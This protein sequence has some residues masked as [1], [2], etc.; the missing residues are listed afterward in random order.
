MPSVTVNAKDPGNPVPN[1]ATC[2]PTDQTI[3]WHL[4]PSAAA[5]AAQPILFPTRAGFGKWPGGKPI[6]N[7]K[8]NTVTVSI[9]QVLRGK[10]EKIPY[11]YTVV[12][13]NGKSFDPDIENTGP[14]GDPDDGKHKPQ[15]RRKKA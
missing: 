15:T 5:F 9:N 3:T 10:S 7:V 11:K 2:S 12:L 1:P 4:V 6:I 13:A 14:G 8:G